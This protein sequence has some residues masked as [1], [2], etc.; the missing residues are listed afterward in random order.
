METSFQEVQ[1]GK[2]QYS[3]CIFGTQ[4]LSTPLYSDKKNDRTV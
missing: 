3:G 2:L 4:D 1:K